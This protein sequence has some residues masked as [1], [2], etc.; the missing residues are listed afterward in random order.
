MRASQ[1]AS[2][3]I[4]SLISRNLPLCVRL[5]PPPSLASVPPQV[6]FVSSLVIHTDEAGT[7]QLLVSY[8]SGDREARIF[9]TPLALL[10]AFNFSAL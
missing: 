5:P 6:A 3:E 10:D 4:K 1:R 8:G 2:T 9:S 7:E